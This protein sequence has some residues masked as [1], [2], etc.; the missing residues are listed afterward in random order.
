[1]ALAIKY[2]GEL[3]THIEDVFDRL[4]ELRW[5]KITKDSDSLSV[6]YS[7]YLFVF[8]FITFFFFY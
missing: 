2:A 1:M 3:K 7:T 4:E 8:S 5:W 6:S